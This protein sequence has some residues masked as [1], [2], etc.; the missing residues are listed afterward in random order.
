MKEQIRRLLTAVVVIEGLRRIDR[1]I[2]RE[3]EECVQAYY[4]LMK[5]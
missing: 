3:Y 1:K 5:P 4:P 2:K